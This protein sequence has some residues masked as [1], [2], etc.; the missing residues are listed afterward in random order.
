MASPEEWYKN[1][2]KV[3]KAYFTVAVGATVLTTMGAVSPMHLYADFDLTF[4]QLQLWRLIT[5]FLWLGG[6]GMKWVFSI[7]ILVQSFNRLESEYYQGVRGL[8][9]FIYLCSFCAILLLAAAYSPLQ[10]YFLGQI[11]TFSVIYIWSRK[12]SQREVILYGFKFKAWVYPFM[13]MLISMILGN[14]LI[15]DVVGILI[16]HLYHFLI[17][18]VPDQYNVR[19]LTTPQFIYNLAGHRDPAADRAGWQR[20]PG[21][22]LN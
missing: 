7:V 3:T 5:P 19:L 18:I 10:I 8:G 15:Y 21:Y 6:F 1:L 4:Y 20:A 22:R 17:D 2:P 14:P 16:G 9:D 11:L 13:L 12:D